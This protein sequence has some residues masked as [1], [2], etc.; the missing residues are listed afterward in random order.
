MFATAIFP[1]STDGNQFFSFNIF[2]INIQNKNL[3]SQINNLPLEKT[4][5][6]SKLQCLKQIFPVKNKT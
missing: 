5:L 2:S 1:I 4:K 6:I 3:L